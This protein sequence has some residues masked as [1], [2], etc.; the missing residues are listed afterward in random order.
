MKN[1]FLKLAAAVLAVALLLPSAL[2]VGVSAEPADFNAVEEEFP[3]KNLLRKSNFDGDDW[4]EGIIRGM[5]K[6]LVQIKTPTGGY[7]QYDKITANYSGITIGNP[8]R[9]ILG[10]K[11]KV[12]A[13]VRMMYIGEVTELRVQVYDYNAMREKGA[14]YKNVATV[15]AYPKS[16]EWMKVEFFCE[17]NPNDMF[18]Y[19][20]ICGG[21]NEAFVQPYCIDNVSLVAVDEIPEGYTL[22]RFGTPVSGQNAI[23][24][25]VDSLFYYPKYYPEYEERY[26]KQGLIINLDADGFLGGAVGTPEELAEYARGYEGTHVTDFMMC[27][28]NTN[29]TYP[30]EVWTSLPEKYTQTKENGVAVNYRETPVAKNAFVHF[31][32]KGEDYI[33]TFCETF[34]EV[35]INPWI[36]FRMNDSHDHEAS[37]KTS[38]LLSE[39][40]HNNPQV[41][42]VHHK[43]YATTSN[44]Y[45]FNSMNY[46]H[47]LVRDNMLA[48][49][50]EAMNRYGAEAYGFELDWQRDMWIFEPGGEYNGIEIINDFMREVRRLADVYEAKYGREYK[51]C[52]RV[53]SDLETNYDLGF[54][55]L[56]WASEGLIDLV[57]PTGRWATV[58][59]NVPVSLWTSMMHPYGVEVA[60]C[61]EVRVQN[62]DGSDGAMQGHTL[63]TYNGF[64]AAFLSQGA[65]KVAIYNYYLGHHTARIQYKHKV[66]TTDEAVAGTWRHFV[67]ATTIGSYDKLMTL[68]RRVIMTYND[69]KALWKQQT[70]QL[71]TSCN[72]GET[73]TLRLSV[74]DIPEEA[75]VTVKLGINAQN[76]AKMPTVYVNGKL[77]EFTTIELSEEGFSKNQLLCFDVPASAFYSPYFVIEVV[78]QRN[79]TLDHCEVTIDMPE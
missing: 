56:T 50:N 53:A 28:N 33:K 31:V 14:Q 2:T 60:P 61:I 52:V 65:D 26:E 1:K 23:N 44:K 71:P 12:T 75:T 76:I 62:Y 43:N 49:I 35:G 59:G 25:Q 67:V 13:Y 69:M 45:Y 17:I 24:S 58:D 57:I 34:N 72:A 66:S 30:S 8:N 78:P 7:L 10:G 15:Y 21:P 63:A 47:K 5:G 79:L 16:D 4:D 41:R 73:V 42:R 36:S 27:V 54:D 3:A 77:A 20:T 29:A 64:A 11:Y 9:A 37:V 51:L 19:I 6:N 48:L 46:T 70:S 39:F 68:D 18:G 55:V 38:V 74:G 22:P 32:G 40:Y